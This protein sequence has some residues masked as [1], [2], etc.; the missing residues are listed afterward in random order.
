VPQKNRKHNRAEEIKN[1][2]ENF[3]TAASLSNWHENRRQMTSSVDP[4]TQSWNLLILASW[5]T[6]KIGLSV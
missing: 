4:R 1:S 6:L 3:Q 5:G 2:K